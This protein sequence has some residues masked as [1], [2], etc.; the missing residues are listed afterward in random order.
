MATC[1]LAIAAEAAAFATPGVRIGLFSTTPMV[2][3]SPPHR[4]Q[5]CSRN[6]S[7]WRA[8]P[9]ENR[10]HKITH[11]INKVVPPASLREDP[12]ALAARLARASPVRLA[13]GQ[14]GL[15]HRDRSR[16][17]Q[18]VSIRQ[19]IMTMNSVAADAEGCRGRH[20]RFS[21]EAPGGPGGG[22][23]A[24]LSLPR[25]CR[26]YFKSITNNDFSPRNF[27]DRKFTRATITHPV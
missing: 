23:E 19:P 15:L 1:D 12:R 8:D 14:A 10:T 21:R 11:K 26:K 27:G 13:I 22:N 6:A 5:A 17:A 25:A 9:V 2:A 3:L 18:S 7:C 16:P 24:R 4:P 20:L